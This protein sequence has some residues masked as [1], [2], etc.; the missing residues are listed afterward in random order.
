MSLSQYFSMNLTKVNTLK[1]TDPNYPE[2]L[3]HI[4]GIPSRL[5]WIGSEPKNWLELPKVAIV[6]SR[7]ISAYGRQ[8]T[9]SLAGELAGA[10]IVIIS[11][12]AFGVDAAAHE[13][14]VEAGGTAVAILPTP[15]ED[16]HPVSN[17]HL[18]RKIIGS[19]GT[20]ISEYS[21]G[22]QIHKNNFIERNRI[23]SGL[24][25]VLLITE[26]AVNSGSLHTAR[27]ALEQGKTV[28]A[29]PGNI[30]SPTSE[31]CNNLIKSG[32]IPVT[33]AKDVFFALNINPA[34]AKKSRAFSGAATEERI[35][36]LIKQGVC[37]QEELALISKLDGPSVNGAL[38]MLEINGYIRAQ[39]AGNWTIA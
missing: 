22:S 4:S 8:V 2:A 5:F 24:A 26:A 21:V 19:G 23:V 35:L 25:D 14:T 12:L 16:I 1:L 28:M 27:F 29:V 15:V 11:G 37:A 36:D 7:K 33:E 31:G 6:G 39:G 34:Q 18:A 30:T 9:S 38:T 32:A 20:L 3:K 13:A 17:Q 10:G